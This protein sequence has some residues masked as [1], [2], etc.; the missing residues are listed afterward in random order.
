M[1]AAFRTDVLAEHEHA[2]IERELC[3]EHAADRRQHVD[4][5]T[6][7]L[8]HCTR[9]RELVSLRCEAT[10]FLQR[11]GQP[12]GAREH[13]ASQLGWIGR[14]TREG[15]LDRPL[16]L[17]PRFSRELRPLLGAN[18]LRNEVSLEPL[19]GV[20]RALF[21]EDGGRFI[22]LGILTGV[23]RQPGHGEAQQVRCALFAHPGDRL[24]GELLHAA[25]LA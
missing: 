10:L 7:W 2:G 1:H 17:A 16:D 13:V 5:C 12:C 25:R 22:C 18:E 15:T 3:I 23:P 20:A 14:R 21:T 9:G 24:E 8:W 4:A 6:V 19:E 11:Y